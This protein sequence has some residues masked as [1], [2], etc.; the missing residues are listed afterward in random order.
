MIRR[1]FM[2]KKLMNNKI[3]FLIFI[4]YNKSAYAYLDPGII[5]NLLQIIIAVIASISVFIY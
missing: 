4:F 2:L 5:S 1:I 3:F